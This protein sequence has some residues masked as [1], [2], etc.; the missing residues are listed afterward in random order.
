MKADHDIRSFTKEL[1]QLR[2]A[3]QEGPG[4]TTMEYRLIKSLLESVESDVESNRKRS[5][6]AR[7]S[8]ALPAARATE[9]LTEEEQEIQ[10]LREFSVGFLED[11][12]R[13][14]LPGSLLK[15]LKA[16]MEVLHADKGNIQL[17]DE[18]EKALKIVT[19][20]GFNQE[21]LDFFRTVRTDASVCG[22]ALI[23]AK[24]VIVRDLFTDPA[25][26][27]L[28]PIGI[29]HGFSA[30]QATPLFG[31]DG[32]LTGMLSTHFRRPHRPSDH[33]LDVLDLYTQHA[34]YAIDLDNS[35]AGRSL[36]ETNGP[37]CL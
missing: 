14:D 24:R 6:K 28:G 13:Q 35:R 11:I 22:A 10:R 7:R 17:Y 25:F 36:H 37:V 9:G 16:C 4:L 34:E 1:L 30:V 2:R 8:P 27:E 32:A 31:T 5:R 18:G 12:K 19:Q 3:L 26:S 33:E 23:Q 29:A 21:F 20:V 15:V